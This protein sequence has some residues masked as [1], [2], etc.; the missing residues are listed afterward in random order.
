MTGRRHRSAAPLPTTAI[1]AAPT[2]GRPRRGELSA[3]VGLCA[4]M[5]MP[6]ANPQRVSSGGPSAS[7]SALRRALRAQPLP[8]SSAN[9]PG[10]SARSRLVP[11]ASG[12]L[13][14]MICRRSSSFIPSSAPDVGR[15]R[16]LS[17]PRLAVMYLGRS[18]SSTDSASLFLGAASPLYPEGAALGRCA[19]LTRRRAQR[20]NPFKGRRA[21]SPRINPPSGCRFPHRLPPMSNALRIEEAA[22]AGRRFR[23]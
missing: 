16:S 1:A 6:G 13:K 10:P 14:L 19:C 21:P 9:E 22:V 7:A 2:L 11:G 17:A 23:P 8:P 18:S 20:I 3:K 5:R 15:R 4:P 12:Q